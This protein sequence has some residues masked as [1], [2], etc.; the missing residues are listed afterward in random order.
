[1]SR[2]ANRNGQSPDRRRRRP[3]AD[4]AVPLPRRPYR[5]SVLFYAA[6]AALIVGVAWATGGRVLPGDLL[7]DPDDG[8]PQVGALLVAVVFFLVATAWSWWRFRRQLALARR[9]L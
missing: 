7:R 9:K 5:D 2:S 3:A 8:P 4:A 6:L 1:M